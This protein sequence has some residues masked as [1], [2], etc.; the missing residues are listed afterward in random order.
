M[1]SPS[2]IGSVLVACKVVSAEQWAGVPA[3]ADLEGVLDALVSTKPWWWDAPTAPPPGLTA[4]QENL[5]RDRAEA[6]DPAGLKAGLT[7]NQFLLLGHLGEGGQ[8]RVYFAR[9]LRPARY[10]AVKTLTRDTEPAR[11]RFEQEAKAMMD[12]AHPSVARFYQYERVRDQFGRLTNDYL[13]AMEYVEGKDLFR[14]VRKGGPAPWRFAVRWT[15]QL[16]SGLDYL[17]TRGFIHRDVKPENVMAVGP[18]AGWGD[19]KA[20]RVKLLDLGAVKPAGGDDVARAVGGRVFVGTPEYAPPEQWSGELVPASDIYA[21]AGTLFF[22]LTDRTPYQKEKRDAFAY[23]KSHVNDPVPD[24]RAFNP[25][26]PEEVAAVVAQMM[27][28]DPAARGTAKQLIAALMKTL[29]ETDLAKPLAGKPARKAP[30]PLPTPIE[31]A[32]PKPREGYEPRQEPG[33]FDAALVLLERLF[34]PPHK[35]P[36][37]DDELTTRERVLAL[38]RRPLVIV[39]F[40]AVLALLV[41]CL[42]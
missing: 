13:I 37:P 11:M 23:M 6:D 33:P 20:T 1:L 15:V 17:H 14:L 12:V 2:E 24:L 41:R 28:K 29:G 4:Y 10:A 19:P 30:R 21:A 16:L 42:W 3:G 38:I 25:D 31:P 7:L 8:G 22:V 26:V 40:L 36:R 9:Q 35:R 18:V 32:V 34:I 39:L 5:I 27:A